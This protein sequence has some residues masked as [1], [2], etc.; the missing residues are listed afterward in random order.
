MASQHTLRA[1]EFVLDAFH[2]SSRTQ[3]GLAT[4]WGASCGRF[5]VSNDVS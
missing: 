3:A 2:S 4:L 1:S 5:L